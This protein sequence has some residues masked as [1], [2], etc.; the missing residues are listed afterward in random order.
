MCCVGCTDGVILTCAFGGSAF[1]R[2]G[3]AGHDESCESDSDSE[4]DVSDS[5][6]DSDP[7]SDAELDELDEDT[8]RFRLREASGSSRAIAFSAW[9][10]AIASTLYTSQ[11]P[12]K[13][14]TPT[15]QMRSPSLRTEIS[16][17]SSRP[18]PSMERCKERPRNAGRVV[19]RTDLKEEMFGVDSG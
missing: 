14:D 11:F 8:H 10:R 19:E 9:S 17:S 6:S 5:D 16:E 2:D 13:R 1:R 4:S 7:V 18:K 15:N 12:V 3:V